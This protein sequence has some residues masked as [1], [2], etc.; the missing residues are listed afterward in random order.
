MKGTARALSRRLC[1]I[2]IY[3]TAKSVILSSVFHR[4]QKIYG[5]KEVYAI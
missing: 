4:L 3:Y 5:K 2:L 1:S